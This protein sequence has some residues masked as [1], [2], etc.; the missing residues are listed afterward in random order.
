M[1]GKRIDFAAVE[2]RGG[3]VGR[4][5]TIWYVRSIW[6][7]RTVFYK[8]GRAL[9]ARI[10]LVLSILRYAIDRLEGSLNVRIGFNPREAIPRG[11]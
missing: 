7:V 6:Y 3:S 10:G 1:N 11:P 5:N 9:R 4:Y 8:T 2:P